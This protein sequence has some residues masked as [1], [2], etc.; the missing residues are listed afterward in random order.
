MSSLGTFAHTP[1]FGNQPV[2]QKDRST[3][4]WVLGWLAFGEG[5]HNNHHAEAANYKFG[6]NSGEADLSARIIDLIQI[7]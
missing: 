1:A 5:W 4:L 7:K 2:L 6:R 3:N